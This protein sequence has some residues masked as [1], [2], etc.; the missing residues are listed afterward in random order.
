MESN[1][2]LERHYFETAF[3]ESGGFPEALIKASGSIINP[4][5]LERDIRKYRTHL[6]EILPLAFERLI[7]QI[8]ECDE[9]PVI[10]ALAHMHLGSH[11]STDLRILQ[12]HRWRDL[13]LEKGSDPTVLSCDALGR[14]AVDRCSSLKFTRLILPAELYK[15]GHYAACRELLSSAQDSN[16]ILH[17]A[18]D[19]MEE[20]YGDSPQNLYFR[21]SIQWRRVHELATTASR[22]SIDDL[23]R[24]EFEAWKGIAEVRISW[25]SESRYDIEK[26][27]DKL[28]LK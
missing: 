21:P 3:Q 10:K 24:S 18:A 17:L 2:R 28:S 27:L 23:S 12:S 5:S 8:E 11:E 14:K 20:V 6:N 15:Q 22:E 4:D 16:K 1:S 7:R 9:T 19:M 25:P 26:H 13:F